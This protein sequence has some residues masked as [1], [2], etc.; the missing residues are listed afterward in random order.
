MPN[1]LGICEFQPNP[2]AYPCGGDLSISSR[3]VDARGQPLPVGSDQQPA[4]I[5]P[6]VRCE[7]CGNVVEG[8]PFIKDEPKEPPAPMDVTKS[9]KLDDF[10]SSE[11]DRVGKLEKQVA[12]QAKQIADLQRKTAGR[13]EAS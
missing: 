12:Q 6:V 9:V 1:P 5:V 13:R 10:A 2:N 8:H 11:R 4:R 3:G 7:E